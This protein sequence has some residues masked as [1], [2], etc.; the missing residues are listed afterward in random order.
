CKARKPNCCQSATTFRRKP[1]MPATL[2]TLRERVEAQTG[3]VDRQRG[4]I[5]G[6]R[7]I[8]RQ[9]TNGRVYSERALKTAARLY[10]GC[11][12]LVDHPRNP[13]DPGERSVRDWIGTLRNVEYRAGA[14][15]GNLHLLKSHPMANQVFEAAETMPANFGLSHNAEGRVVRENG[16]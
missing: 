8:G 16:K 2:T 12:V 9:S 10:E 15:Y 6:V 5:R 14:V 4:I 7:I 1:A 13:G 3:R 11:R